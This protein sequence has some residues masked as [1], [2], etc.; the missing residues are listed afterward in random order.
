M[1]YACMPAS[2]YMIQTPTTCDDPNCASQRETLYNHA[3]QYHSTTKTYTPSR[4][5][6]LMTRNRSH[7]LPAADGGVLV[8]V[9]RYRLAVILILTIPYLKVVKWRV[10]SVN[11]VFFTITPLHN[12][13]IHLQNKIIILPIVG[14]VWLEL[15]I[16]WSVVYRVSRYHHRLG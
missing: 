3:I 4:N 8:L 1:I 13:H 14:F 16:S 9:P 2:Q 12:E 15:L 10:F 7:A 5:R 11:R 6:K